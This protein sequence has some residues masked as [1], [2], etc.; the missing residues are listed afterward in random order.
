MA[1]CQV[2]LNLDYERLPRVDDGTEQVFGRIL[3]TTLMDLRRS[4]GQGCH[5]CSILQEGIH[6]VTGPTN[7][8]PH[9]DNFDD[10]PLLTRLRR[11][12]NLEVRVGDVV[13]YNT[14]EFYTHLGSGLNV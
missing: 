5:T 3:Q 11:G 7:H 13:A 10:Q 9:G 4:T 1:V 6:L 12:R 2:C 8:S 14:I